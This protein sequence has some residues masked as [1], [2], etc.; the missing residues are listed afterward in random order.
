MSDSSRAGRPP[1]TVL[2]VAA[3]GV[4]LGVIAGIYGIRIIANRDDPEV[5]ADV[6]ASSGWLLAYG[7]VAIGLGVVIGLL[8]VTLA[9]GS[10]SARWTVGLFALLHLLQGFAIVFQW[11]DVGAWEGVSSIV[12]SAAILYL[13]FRNPSTR[14]YYARV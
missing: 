2:I 5:V 3:L 9:R 11:Y 1:F 8:A 14:A 6:G 4:G 10:T 12:V 7:V 13:L